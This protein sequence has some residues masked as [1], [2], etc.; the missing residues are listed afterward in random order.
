MFLGAGLDVRVIAL[1][2]GHDPDSFVRAEG[3]AALTE[4]VREAPG[5]V[6]FARAHLLDRLEKREDLLKAFAFLGSRID[7]PIRRRVL[8]QEAAESFRFE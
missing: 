4:R 8:L 6:G 3:P 7:D 1:P 2:E 5:V